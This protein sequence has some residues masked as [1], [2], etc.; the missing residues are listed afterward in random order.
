MFTVNDIVQN[1]NTI[2]QVIS[3][4]FMFTVNELELNSLSTLL[5]FQNISC[6]RLIN[7]RHFC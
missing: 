2:E 7:L 6:L 3:K 4:H 1:I 5:Q